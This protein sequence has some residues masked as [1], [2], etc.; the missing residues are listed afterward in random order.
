MSQEQKEISNVLDS[1][2]TLSCHIHDDPGT[3]KSLRLQAQNLAI[4]LT[5]VERLEPVASLIRRAERLPI[6]RITFNIK[7]LSGHDGR[8]TKDDGNRWTRVQGLGFVPA[9]FCLIAIQGLSSLSNNE[10]DSLLTNVGQY[11]TMQD[12]PPDWICTQEIRECLAKVPRTTQ[13]AQFLESKSQSNNA[14]ACSYQN[15]TNQHSRL[16]H[17]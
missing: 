5:M 10:Y 8:H 9:L 3:L 7:T 12:L 2:F 4:W 1:A 14:N 11:L 15:I 6:R 13:T 17:G 16:S